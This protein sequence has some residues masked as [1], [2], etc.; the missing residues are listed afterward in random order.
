[1]IIESPTLLKLKGALFLILGLVAGGLLLAPKFSWQSLLLLLLTVWAFCRAYYF[2]FYVLHYYA[3]PRF[4]YTG[5]GS[6]VMY[7]ITGRP[8]EG[9]GDQAGTGLDTA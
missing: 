4:R 5:I 7:L 6:A 9:E 8:P 3:D 2:C 1:M